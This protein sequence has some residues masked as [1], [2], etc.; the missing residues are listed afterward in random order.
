MLREQ[1]EETCAKG[2][3]RLRVLL[4]GRPGVGKS[5][6]VNSAASALAKKLVVVAATGRT[7][8]GGNDNFT[9]R[10]FKFSVP[11]RDRGAALDILDVPGSEFD[12][13][14]PCASIC[15]N[16]ASLF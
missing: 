5:S 14:V 3:R 6:F 7:G 9:L 13:C 2:P 11:V 4:L 12:V 1:I 8:Q 15:V 16:L 10:R